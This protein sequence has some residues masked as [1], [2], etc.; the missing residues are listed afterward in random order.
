MDE[1]AAQPP[2]NRPQGVNGLPNE[3]SLA[4][5]EKLRV[6][7]NSFLIG[8]G[9]AAR[10]LSAYTLHDL[11]SRQFP[12][13]AVSKTHMYRLLSGDAIPRLDLILAVAEICGIEPAY[14]LVDDLDIDDAERVGSR[15]VPGFDILLRDLV[16][17]HDVATAPGEEP[18]RLTGYRLY[19]ILTE[20]YPDVA[21]SKSHLYR[22]LS[23][24]TP[25]ARRPSA[26]IPRLDLIFAFAN[27]FDVSPAYFVDDRVGVKRSVSRLRRP[28]VPS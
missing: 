5:A 22:L 14:F 7:L 23:G 6:V 12:D 10:P 19:Q 8:E 17:S 15:E 2:A 13:V 24:E 28:P 11:I 27:I 3:I 25:P 20:R 21:V 1:P 26:T 9:D 16:D 4:F 18:R